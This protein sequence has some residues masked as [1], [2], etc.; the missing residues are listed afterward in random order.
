MLDRG[1]SQDNALSQ[2]YLHPHLYGSHKNSERFETITR[3][4]SK[5]QSFFLERRSFQRHCRRRDSNLKFLNFCTAE[6]NIDPYRQI[7]DSQYDDTT[8]AHKCSGLTA[9]HKLDTV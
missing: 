3:V 5:F 6:E 8:S 4:E 9:R 2:N 1:G 7:P